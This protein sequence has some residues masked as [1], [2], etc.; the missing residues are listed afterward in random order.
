MK[1][2]CSPPHTIPAFGRLAG[3]WWM[4]ELIGQ[5]QRRKHFGMLETIG[6]LC[7]VGVGSGRECVE[8]PEHRLIAP[9]CKRCWRLLAAQ[10]QADRMRV[11]G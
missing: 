10:V 1:L 11:V 5:R 4:L 3:K 9:P 8:A 6:G 7:A 2:P